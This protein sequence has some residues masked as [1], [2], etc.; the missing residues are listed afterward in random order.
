M[1]T[2][3]D[4][5]STD[6][7]IEQLEQALRLYIHEVSHHALTVEYVLQRLNKKAEATTTSTSNNNVD[8]T[9]QNEINYLS[10]N[11]QDS[12]RVLNLL[13]SNIRIGLNLSHGLFSHYEDYS[14]VNIYRDVVFKL[15]NIHQHELNHKNLSFITPKV[16]FTDDA[17]MAYKTSKK[18]L[19][20]ILFNII[21]NAVKFS[22]RGTN[23]Y[24]ECVQ[25]ETSPTYRK[26]RVVDYG[27]H[28]EE[29]GNPYALYYRGV[30]SALSNSGIGLGLYVAQK[31]VS[32]LGGEI[33][34]RCSLISCFHIPFIKEYLGR[35]LNESTECELTCKLHEESKR[36]M[37]NDTFNRI[38]S[39]QKFNNISNDEIRS[40]IYMPTYETVFEVVI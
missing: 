17:K 16:T 8:V 30:E 3:N 37:K 12:L 18:F 2:S 22:H 31:L 34:H 5:E 29:T 21:N 39:N 10:D 14:D 38:V 40:N 25:T 4:K 6:I 27:I 36:L 23:I 35:Q 32:Q 7:R 20:L 13:E 28:V 9:L 24:V 19:E 33:Y 26:I 15:K 11:L 1:R